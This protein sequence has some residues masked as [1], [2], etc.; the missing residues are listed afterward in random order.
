MENDFQERPGPKRPPLKIMMPHRFGG[1]PQKTTL[2]SL[3][4]GVCALPQGIACCFG[5]P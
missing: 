4:K 2:F 1:Q 3:K 5:P